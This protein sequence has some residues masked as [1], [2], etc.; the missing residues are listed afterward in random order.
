MERGSHPPGARM[1]DFQEQD[2]H[3]QGGETHSVILQTAWLCS[4]GV[5]VQMG[6]SWIIYLRK[7]PESPS[8]LNA[9]GEGSSPSGW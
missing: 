6:D 8:G 7:V 5:C 3:P 9:L 1:S 2:L 4:T